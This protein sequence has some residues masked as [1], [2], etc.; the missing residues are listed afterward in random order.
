M[1][2]SVSNRKGSQ[3]RLR[4]L[5][6]RVRRLEMAVAGRAVNIPVL[7][8][9][10]PLVPHRE[11]RARERLVVD[12]FRDTG[13]VVWGLERITSEPGD[14]GQSC[15]PGGCIES[16]LRRFHQICHWRTISGTCRMCQGTAVANGKTGNGVN[17]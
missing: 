11:L 13:S 4:Q 6:R 3:M 9:V 1:L 14:D 12:R 8:L 2:W 16:I 17:G 7:I 15:E 5:D 10:E